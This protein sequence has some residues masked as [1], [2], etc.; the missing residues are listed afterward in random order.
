MKYGLRGGFAG[1]LL[2]SLV[3]ATA[4]GAARP[5]KDQF[6][7]LDPT[8]LRDAAGDVQ[9]SDGGG[10]Y[11]LSD[12]RT[13]FV[14]DFATSQP[15]DNG[16]TQTQD[17]FY[18]DTGAGG[19]RTTLLSSSLASTNE[20]GLGSTQDIRCHTG[21]FF[22]QSAV[23]PEWYQELGPVGSSVKGWGTT[24]CYTAADR[25]YHLVYPGH[26][27]SA[28]GE[29]LTMTQSGTDTLTLTAP[30]GGAIDPLGTSCA[31]TVYSFA[32]VDGT[33]RFTLLGTES[34]PFEL[35]LTLPPMKGKSGKR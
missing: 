12:I 14:H 17:Y 6:L 11:A 30:S 2:L 24:G 28:A 5:A 31:A 32:I 18:L 29:C 9:L 23:T 3:L 22:F 21:Y 13:A 15:D 1:G 4:A 35:T 25:G 10:P 27:Q 26:T 16:T 20:S 34:A 7:P 33:K 19:S 8:A